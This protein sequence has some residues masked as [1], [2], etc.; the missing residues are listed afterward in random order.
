MP[1]LMQRLCRRL[2][3]LSEPSTPVEKGVE[4]LDNAAALFFVHI[5]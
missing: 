2:L 1:D 4:V 5:L 3:K